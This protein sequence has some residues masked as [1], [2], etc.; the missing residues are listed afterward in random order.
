MDVCCVCLEELGE[1]DISV[2]PCG[3]RFHASCLTE[4]RRHSPRC[5]M[6]RV[7]FVPLAPEYVRPNNSECTTIWAVMSM[8]MSAFAMILL[9]LYSRAVFLTMRIT[10][11]RM[12][13]LC[14]AITSL[15]FLA[16]LYLL[17]VRLVQLA[18]ARV[19]PQNQLA[20]RSAWW[21]PPV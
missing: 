3:H 16:C 6:C 7:A 9:V 5:P 15:S 12:L 2:L 14:A 8:F 13:L 10:G 11:A 18:N 21:A 4:C 20:P 17:L 19:S 1:S